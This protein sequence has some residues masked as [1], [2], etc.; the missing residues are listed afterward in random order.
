MCPIPPKKLAPKA[1]KNASKT[2]HNV[3][4]IKRAVPPRNLSHM[5]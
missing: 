1:C 5:R 3:G 4:I 2:N